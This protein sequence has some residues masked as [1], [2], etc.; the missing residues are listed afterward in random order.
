MSHASARA[1][2]LALP[3]AL[4]LAAV[5]GPGAAHLCAQVGAPP[6]AGSGPDVA[7]PNGEL[8]VL[9][10]F[11][12]DWSVRTARGEEVEL[13]SLRG[14]V[15]VVNFW[16]T[17]CAPCV[18]ELGSFERL[19]RQLEAADSGVRFLYVSPEEPDRVGAFA[20]RHGWDLDLVTEGRR[21]PD[22]LGELVLPT[23]FVVDRE[24]RIVLRHRGASDWAQPEITAFL[25]SLG[26]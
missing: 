1:A 23:T 11:D 25:F 17:W 18:A 13:E 12:Y 6:G 14:E 10:A 21:A 2:L 5:P 3:V 16:A 24:G 7:V 22:T 4:A 8:E 15:L 9:G 20:A 19:E 26:G